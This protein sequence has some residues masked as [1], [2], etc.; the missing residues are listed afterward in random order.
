MGSSARVLN[1]P[2]SAASAPRPV[3]LWTIALSQQASTRSGLPRCRHGH[4]GGACSARAPRRVRTTLRR[5]DGRPLSDSGYLFDNEAREAEDRFGALAALF[6]PV[7][8][9]HLDRLGVAEGWSCLEVGAGGGSV[10]SWLAERV[11]ESGHVV[12]TD[13]DIRW[14]EQRLRAPN[15]EV[16]RHDVAAEPLPESSFDVV[17]ERLVLLHVR[18]RVAALHRLAAAVRPGGW[19]LVEDFDSDIAPDPFPAPRSADEELGNKMMRAVRTLL[20]QRG[21]DT[22]F[23]HQLPDLLRAAGLEEI[24]ADAYQAI[25]AGDAIR[26]LQRANIGQVRGTLVEQALVSRAELERYRVLLEDQWINPSSPLLVS[27]WGRRPPS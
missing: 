6:D 20:A 14:L 15:V 1:A 19:L 24:G 11:G 3:V 23:G 22:A 10:A 25:E 21:A 4:T 16:R 2:E 27:A 18:E 26:Q 5:G 9:R 8:L 12:A 17:H 7:S 13:V